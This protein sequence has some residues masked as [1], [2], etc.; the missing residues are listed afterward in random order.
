MIKFIHK[1]VY[2]NPVGKFYLFPYKKLVDIGRKV[3]G[4]CGM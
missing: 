1:M 3:F 4:I 2:D